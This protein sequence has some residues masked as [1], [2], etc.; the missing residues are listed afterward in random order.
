MVFHSNKLESSLPTD[1]LCHV[2][3]KLA[4]WFWRRW[5]KYKPITDKQTDGQANGRQT[6]G[7]QKRAFS[8]GELHF[9]NSVTLRFTEQAI[10]FTR[11]FLHW[12][13]LD[14]QN[15]NEICIFK[16]A[17]LYTEQSY[18]LCD[19]WVFLKDFTKNVDRYKRLNT[20][21]IINSDILFYLNNAYM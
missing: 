5:W 3:F 14:L 12:H 11:R 18:S 16:K 13:R 8:C 10:I 2:S 21:A 6:T 1:D 9:P 19:R 4:Q 20:L 7:D 15:Q 17:N